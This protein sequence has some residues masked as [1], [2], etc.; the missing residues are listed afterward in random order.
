MSCVDAT[1]AALRQRIRTDL[2][3]T[4]FFANPDEYEGGELIIEDTYGSKSV[5]LPSGCFH[6]V[7]TW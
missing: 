2:S 7:F 5:K 1:A 4:L 3:C 6:E